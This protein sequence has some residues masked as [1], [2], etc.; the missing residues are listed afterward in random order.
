M[1]TPTDALT[2]PGDIP[3][4][5]RMCSP[6][7]GRWNAGTNDEFSA[8]GVVCRRLADDSAGARWLCWFATSRISLGVYGPMPLD[9]TD[10]TGRAHA[11]WW[12]AGQCGKGEPYR[13]GWWYVAGFQWH[14]PYRTW[15]D[16]RRVRMFTIGN[17]CAWADRVDPN[18]DGWMRAIPALADL[19][20]DD[21]RTLPDGSRW[22]AAEALRRVVLHVAGRASD[23]EPT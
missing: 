6:V 20:P 14:Q 3:G 9:L 16:R 17:L 1:T 2:L 7:F 4:L 11:A 18:D 15:S 19:D 10:A 23:P 8:R 21:P 5:L 13:D 22:V 12:L